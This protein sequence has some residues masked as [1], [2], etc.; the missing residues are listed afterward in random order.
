MPNVQTNTELIWPYIHTQIHEIKPNMFEVPCQTN[1]T[2]R[3]IMAYSDRA[4]AGL[5]PGPILSWTL[6]TETYSAIHKAAG[7]LVT[8][9]SQK[10]PLT[11]TPPP[12]SLILLAAAPIHSQWTLFCSTGIV[13]VEIVDRLG[14]VGPAVLWIALL[15]RTGITHTDYWKFPR[16][17]T[18]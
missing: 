6:R 2:A 9:C 16:K 1:N 3:Q 10:K 4:W 7:Y 12:P 17:F 14:A 13:P 15:N 8:G 5:G 11:G 18:G